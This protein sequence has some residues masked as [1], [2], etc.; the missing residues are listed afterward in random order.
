MIYYHK[1]EDIPEWGARTVQRL[2]NADALRGDEN[3]DLDLS[4]DMLRIL[5]ILDR[6][7]RL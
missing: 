3:G 2:L 7:G 4:R 1:L 6:L 5:V